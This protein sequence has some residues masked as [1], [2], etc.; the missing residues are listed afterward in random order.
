MANVP[1]GIE[2]LPKISIAWV[3]CTNITD[4]QTDVRQTDERTTTYS[5]HERDEFMFANNM[6][7]VKTV[8]WKFSFWRRH[9]LVGSGQYFACGQLWVGSEI[10]QVG[11]DHKEWT[12]VEISDE[13]TVMSNYTV[14]MFS[15]IG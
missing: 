1:Y 4:R 6:K 5:E 10:W 13:F 2:T 9:E 7:E 14:P 8:F 11:S 3:G 12:R 15:D